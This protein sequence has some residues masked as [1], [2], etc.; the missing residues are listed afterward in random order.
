MAS[1]DRT[2]D[3]FE[4]R[5]FISQRWKEQDCGP[6]TFFFL[7]FFS[8]L[9]SMRSHITSENFVGLLVMFTILRSSISDLLVWWDLPCYSVYNRFCLV[10][11]SWCIVHATSL[12]S[13]R[14]LVGSSSWSR[15]HHSFFLTVW[16]W[17]VLLSLPW[18]SL[19]NLLV[20]YFIRG[21]VIICFSSCK[22]Y[23]PTKCDRFL[24]SRIWSE[25]TV[26]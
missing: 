4:H 11:G 2:T 18:L 17:H 22:P 21:R 23:I 5:R 20:G 12:G 19:I 25:H 6:F 16:S 7:P 1:I 3:I 13:I 9:F 24:S 15:R 8:L 14:A 10:L 26:A